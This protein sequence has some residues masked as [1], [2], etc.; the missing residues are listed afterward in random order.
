MKYISRIQSLAWLLGTACL[1]ISG[2]VLKDRANPLDPSGNVFVAPATSLSISDG[3]VGAA[4]ARLVYLSWTENSQSNFNSFTGFQI[5]YSKTT[6]RPDAPFTNVSSVVR[7]VTLPVDSNAG[8]THYFWVAPT[9]QLN[10]LP[11]ATNLV[12]AATGWTLENGALVC[13]NLPG[14]GVASVGFSYT[15]PLIPV[16]VNANV[17]VNY[18]V[19][20]VGSTPN[21]SHQF[22]TIFSNSGG[23]AVA[24]PITLTSNQTSATTVSVGSAS[25]QVSASSSYRIILSVSNQSSPNLNGYL[26]NKLVVSSLT[27]STNGVSFTVPISSLNTGNLSTSLTWGNSVPL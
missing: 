25:L 20:A 4:G 23:S 27:F 19:L 7:N 16:A 8:M 13:N 18:Y 3:G 1:I 9:N 24:G 15:G 21:I 10:V 5:Y 12:V 11:V 17:F 6:N 26:A 14:N 22:Q 2:C